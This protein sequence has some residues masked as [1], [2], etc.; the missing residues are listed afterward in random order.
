M[1]WYLQMLLMLFREENCRII[2]TQGKS[3]EYEYVLYL[4]ADIINYLSHSH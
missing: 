4:G 1:F 2:E 3:Y